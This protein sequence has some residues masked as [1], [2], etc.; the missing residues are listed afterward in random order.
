MHYFQ[1]LKEENAVHVN[2]AEQC[3]HEK[4]K[5]VLVLMEYIEERFHLFEHYSDCN[6]GIDTKIISVDPKYGGIGIGNKLIAESIKCAREHNV[7]LFHVM[8]SSHFSA[9]VCEKL[10]FEKLYE[11][12]FVDYVINGENPFVPAAPHTAVR[13]Y[14]QRL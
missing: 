4:F 9:R 5:K 12:P 1:M 2:E 7:Q 6:L 10:G 13:L 11:L 8:C 14:V 3:E